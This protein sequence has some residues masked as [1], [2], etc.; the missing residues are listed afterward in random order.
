LDIEFV[1]RVIKSSVEE[2]LKRMRQADE[3]LAKAQRTTRGKDPQLAEA[4][5]EYNRC[6]AELVDYLN[7]SIRHSR[8]TKE[9]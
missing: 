7:V 3:E 9:V 8:A 2:A 4:L 1:E 5:E 6:V